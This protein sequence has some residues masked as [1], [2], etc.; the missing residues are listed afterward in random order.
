ML[1]R[2]VRCFADRNP[3]GPP[4]VPSGDCPLPGAACAA[5][6]AAVAYTWLGILQWATEC[7]PKPI[8]RVTPRRRLAA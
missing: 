2:V 8:P 7:R 3:A 1:I 5:G 6:L 4:S